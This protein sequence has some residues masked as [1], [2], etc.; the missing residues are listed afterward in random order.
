[1]IK[2][3]APM[4]IGEMTEPFN[5]PD[6]IFELKLDG[7]RCI[8]YL[9]GE[10]RLLNKRFLDVTA[11]YPELQEAHNQ[12]NAPCVL[13]GE[14][15]AMTDGKPDF[16]VMQRRSLMGDIVKIAL[17]AQ[18]T[19]V[20]FCAFDILYRD[21]ERLTGRP[22][23]ERRTLLEKTVIENER[24]SIS[25]YIETNGVA[26]YHL[27]ASQELEGIV[28]KRKTSLYHPGKR[29]KDWIK[30][31]NLKDNDFV[32]CGYIPKDNNMTS[33]I[34]GQYHD[35]GVLVYQGH[36]TLG[37]TRAGLQ[38]IPQGK[39]PF[40][41]VPD[42]NEG[43]IWLAPERV[44]TVRYMDRTASGHMRQPVFHEWRD[45]KLPQECVTAIEY[46]DA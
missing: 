30:I 36:V 21:G 35:G 14:V 26:F 39:C 2:P 24:L 4:L 20:N 46:A 33:L 41:E 10:T 45:D 17:A 1:M 12:V 19:P 27:V 5:S 25:R 23:M 9:D 40:A 15:F 16:S 32:V 22:W 42:G 18:K 44:C 31:K 29:T 28:A 8:A 13:D 37:V 6:Y 34:L 7:I 38:D 3:V 11:T 43:A